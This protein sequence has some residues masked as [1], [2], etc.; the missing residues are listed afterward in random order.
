MT[1]ELTRE[2]IIKLI[3]AL[4]YFIEDTTNESSADDELVQRLQRLL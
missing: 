1:L 2:E 3:N 4:R